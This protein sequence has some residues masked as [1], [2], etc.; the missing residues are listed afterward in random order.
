MKKFKIG[1]NISKKIVATDNVVKEIARVS[2]DI[3]PIHLDDEY[4][5]KT[6]FGKRIAHGLFCLNGISMIIGNDFPGKGSILL[7]QSFKYCKPVYIDDTIE[8]TITIT[9]IKQE[10]GIILLDILCKNQHDEVVLEGTTNVKW[11]EEV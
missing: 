10:K 6:I 1:D 4:A 8:I 11:E 2:G 5:K 7:S 3:N 9:N